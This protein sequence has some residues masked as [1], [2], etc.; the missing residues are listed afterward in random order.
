MD[1]CTCAV[2]RIRALQLS[3]RC[4][5][6]RISTLLCWMKW[7]LKAGSKSQSLLSAAVKKRIIRD[8][9]SV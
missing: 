5:E 7:R 8:D 2:R 1:F 4:I 9:S 6:R 3:V